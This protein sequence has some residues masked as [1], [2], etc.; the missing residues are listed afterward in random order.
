MKVF[1][2]LFAGVVAGLAMTGLGWLARAVGLELNA[3]MMLGTMLGYAP[4]ENTWLIGLGLHLAISAVIALLYAA[5]FEVVAHRAGAAAGFSFSI[6]HVL[7][8]GLFMALMPAL[9][10]MIPEQMPAP[11]AFLV[12]MGAPNVMLFIVEHLMYGTLV[13]ALYGTVLH[14]RARP[15]VV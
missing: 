3:E 8:A 4:G 9:H 5:A 10:P 15:V 7:I 11:G 6:V 14:P 12:N 1:K 2:A 13:G